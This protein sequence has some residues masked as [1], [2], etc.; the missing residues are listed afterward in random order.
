MVTGEI[1]FFMFIL[2]KPSCFSIMSVGDTVE[3]NTL[4][5]YNYQLLERSCEA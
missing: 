2:S 3:Q 5:V 4:V 1:N